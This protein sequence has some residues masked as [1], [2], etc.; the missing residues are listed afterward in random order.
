MSSMQDCVARFSF[1]TRKGACPAARAARS[2]QYDMSLYMVYACAV[3]LTFTGFTL[4]I[5]VNLKTNL[6]ILILGILQH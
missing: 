1:T 5:G 6:L 3:L 4:H 2:T